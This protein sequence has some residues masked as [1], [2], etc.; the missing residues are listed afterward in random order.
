LFGRF[1][2]TLL[3]T[4]SSDTPFTFDSGIFAAAWNNDVVMTVTGYR[5]GQEVATGSYA[6]NTGFDECEPGAP[7]FCQVIDETFPID[8]TFGWQDIDTLTFQ[9]VGGHSDGV[10]SVLFST[11]FQA[12]I[13][14][15]SLTVHPY[16]TPEPGTLGLLAAGLIVAAATTRFNPAGSSLKTNN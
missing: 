10:G 6:L 14:F 2:T 13:N 15:G 7:P 4:I 16:E 12:N 3:G 8:I 1:G 11:D 9:G 5:N